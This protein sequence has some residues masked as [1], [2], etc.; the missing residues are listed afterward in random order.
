MLI[1][2]DDERLRRLCETYLQRVG[3]EVV[4]CAE[5][6]LAIEAARQRHFDLLL[7]DLKMPG[8]S[9]MQLIEL[10]LETH[11]NIWVVVMSGSTSMDGEAES[12][13]VGE[14]PFIN[15]PFA[16]SALEEIIRDVLERGGNGG[17]A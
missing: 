4:T 3:F 11:P 6:T 16:L 17:G 8:M 13:I 15:K 9:G 1:V 12:G 5:A 7:T 10:I 14:Y 2:D